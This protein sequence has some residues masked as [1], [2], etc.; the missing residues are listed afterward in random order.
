MAVVHDEPPPAVLLHR[1]HASL[2]AEADILTSNGSSQDTPA[3][4]AF[5]NPEGFTIPREGPARGRAIAMWFFCME[6]GL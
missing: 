2:A 3:V 4:R 6:G 1:L 5:S